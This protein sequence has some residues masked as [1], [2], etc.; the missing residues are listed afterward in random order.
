MPVGFTRYVVHY[1]NNSNNVEEK[2]NRHGRHP[3]FRT[4]HKS[5]VFGE[6][7]ATG[8]IITVGKSNTC[9]LVPDLR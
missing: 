8:V 2:S 5:V 4:L 7:G 9:H 6:E 3:C 1:H